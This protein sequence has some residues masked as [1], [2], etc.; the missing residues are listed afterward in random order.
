[1]ILFRQVG[2]KNKGA[3]L[4]LRSMHSKACEYYGATNL[5]IDVTSISGT[6]LQRSELGLWSMPKL[7]R[8]GIQWGRAVEFMPDR[9]INPFGLVKPSQV[10]VVWD[11]AGYA[12]TDKWGRG[13]SAE[14]CDA[15]HFYKKAGAKFVFLPQAFGPFSDLRGSKSVRAALEMADLVFVRDSVSMRYLASLGPSDFDSEKYSICPDFTA[16]TNVERAVL[17]KRSVGLVPNFRICD[18]LGM[19]RAAYISELRKLVSL[20]RS[21]DFHAALII[22]E[23]DD[24]QIISEIS[25]VDIYEGSALELKKILGG[26]EIVV[27]SRYHACISAMSQSVPVISLGWAHKYAQ[28]HED[29]G[30][31][32][33][34]AES[35]SE[36]PQKIQF[37]LDHSSALR[38]VL[39]ESG[40][41]ISDSITRMWER[42]KLCY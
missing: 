27:S 37:A 29:W 21:L 38:N 6:Y 31:P 4:M 42:V 24:K 17:P 16:T 3:E 35:F 18:K 32:E 13:L 33:L 40:A 2:F 12:Y 1:M 34:Y 39:D 11:G 19:P 8:G 14:L 26:C 28:L 22:H 7:W 5:A 9:F 23:D 30:V 15:V 10:G 25:E 36:I 41:V 20:I